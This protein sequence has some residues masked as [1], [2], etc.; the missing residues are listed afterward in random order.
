MCPTSS[1]GAPNFDSITTTKDNGLFG[2]LHPSRC[3]FVFAD[4]SVHSIIY[5][6][7]GPTFTLLGNIADGSTLPASDDW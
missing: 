5:S 6:I 1:P 3:Q 2:S 4:D 7:S